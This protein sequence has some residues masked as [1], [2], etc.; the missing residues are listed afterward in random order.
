MVA[1]LQNLPHNYE[2]DDGHSEIVGLVVQQV[3]DHSV[4]PFGQ[5]S[6]VRFSETVSS[7]EEI[8]PRSEGG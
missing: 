2:N 6:E 5:I 8:I 7:R 4:V 1:F 3:A